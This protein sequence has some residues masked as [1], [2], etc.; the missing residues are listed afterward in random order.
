ME[1][2]LKP[3]LFWAWGFPG[4]HSTMYTG[5]CGKNNPS[6]SPIEENLFQ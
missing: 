4:A 6:Q 5:M 2:A 3:G 1:D